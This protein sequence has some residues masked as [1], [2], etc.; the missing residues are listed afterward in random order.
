MMADDGGFQ[1]QIATRVGVGSV[2]A[3]PG[4]FALSRG[5]VDATARLGLGGDDVTATA[6]ASA[7]K[8]RGLG[9]GAALAFVLAD[10]DADR[11][12][13]LG[14]WSVAVD[15][16]F[17][18]HVD[19]RGPSRGQAVACALGYDRIGGACGGCWCCGSGRR[20]RSAEDGRKRRGDGALAALGVSVALRIDAQTALVSVAR[21][22]V[23]TGDIGLSAVQRTDIAAS[24]AGV[25]EGRI[26]A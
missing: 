22:M 3:S 6:V 26:G 12:Q 21:A 10:I 5:D 17:R 1:D 15:Q 19:R 25:I 8:G 24:A 11:E 23:A 7:I 18:H 4:A 16:P 20:D 9:I 13:G 2:A 14:L